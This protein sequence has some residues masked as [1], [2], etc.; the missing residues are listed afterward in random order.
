MLHT[1]FRKLAGS[2]WKPDYERAGISQQFNPEFYKVIG[3]ENASEYDSV[4]RFL[5]DKAERFRGSV[6]FA[7]EIPYNP[8]FDLIQ[9]L[10][11]ELGNMDLSQ[12][13]SADILLFSNPQV[14]SLFLQRLATVTD[15]YESQFH[16]MNQSVKIDFIIK[17]MLWTFTYLKPIEDTFSNSA[18]PKCIYYG[19][20]S[21]HESY[22]LLLVHL[23]GFDV[24][25]I[26]PLKDQLNE[27]PQLDCVNTIRYQEIAPVGNILSRIQN[28][29]EIDLE[30]STTA[31]LMDEIQQNIFD[32]GNVF[33][34]WQLKDFDIKPCQKSFTLFDLKSNISE[35]AK[36]R[37]GFEL[38]D[39][40]L[41]TPN[42]FFHIDGVP[43]NLDEYSDLVSLV[44]SQENTL[45]FQDD[46]CHLFTDT[47]DED[48]FSLVFC[49]AGEKRYNTD[50]IKKLPF[51]QWAKYNDHVERKLLDGI[52][53]L[54][55]AG[56]LPDMDDSEEF[57]LISD[58][59]S[60]KEDIIQL[61]DNYDYA[62]KIP[63]LVIF[64]NN[65]AFVESQ[66]ARILAYIYE[67][68]F[69]VIIFNPSGLHRIGAFINEDRVNIVRNEKMVYD[70]TYEKATAK[71][72]PRGFWAKLF[73]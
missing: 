67:L 72:K 2:I 31:Q 50:E 28:A 66:V 49:R 13:S 40:V 7:S 3:I 14:N 65:N 30:I 70:M 27:L 10:S 44:V 64:L 45:V 48:M 56:I 69:D 46:S 61:L 26:N 16:F 29:P 20:I 34:P 38:R 42:I 58:I 6:F 57:R 17:L 62:E 33:R 19:D 5:V 73:Q 68:G 52:N 8:D 37:D 39:G 51:Y 32:G 11:M 35:P 18:C 24:L 47:N 54:L 59:L 41:I 25:Y 1:S 36:V 43:D 55:S 71:K 21:R 63:K 53:R 4:I 22:F 23:M 15:L 60:I 12:L 9:N